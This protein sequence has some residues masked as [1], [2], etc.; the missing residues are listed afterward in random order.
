MAPREKE[1]IHRQNEK[2]FVDAYESPSGPFK[3]LSSKELN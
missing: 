3:W 2:N 1:E